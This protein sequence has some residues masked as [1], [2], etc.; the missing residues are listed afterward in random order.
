MEETFY[1]D[2]KAIG[3]SELILT[4]SGNK[5]ALELIREGYF[6][7]KELIEKLNA[8]NTLL[9]KRGVVEKPSRRKSKYYFQK[10]NTLQ[11]QSL[12]KNT[13][14]RRIR[15]RDLRK[16]WIAR[17]NAAAKLNGT[18]Y[19]KLVVALKKANIELNRKLL[20]D[21]A[22]RDPSAFAAII[23]RIQGRST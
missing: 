10:L 3:I 5:L 9:K 6:S 15:K 18:T 23:A 7:K 8:I 20:S 19:A 2:I 22:L 13:Q 14:D 1:S 11:L 21:M 17:I 4:R 16:L 12:W